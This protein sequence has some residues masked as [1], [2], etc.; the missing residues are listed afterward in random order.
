MWEGAVTDWQW[1]LLVLM[2]SPGP[3]LVLVLLVLGYDVTLLVH[4]R[5][6]RRRWRDQG[7]GGE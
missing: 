2:L 5:D 6:G 1:L 7:R 3:V 4:R